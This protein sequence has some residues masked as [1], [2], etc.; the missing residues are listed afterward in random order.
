MVAVT[1]AL[2]WYPSIELIYFTL[3][4]V[5]F[6]HDYTIFKYVAVYWQE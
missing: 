4:A 3:L 6:I 5:E 1:G 2:R